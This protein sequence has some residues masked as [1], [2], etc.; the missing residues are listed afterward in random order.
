VKGKEW[1]HKF[2]S[3][4]TG[5]K[6]YDS[7]LREPPV[8]YKALYFL[9]YASQLKCYNTVIMELVVSSH[10]VKRLM[11]THTKIFCN[12]CKF[13]TQFLNYSFL[14]LLFTSQC[15]DCP[16]LCRSAMDNTK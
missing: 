15:G 7:V 14:L 5:I 6:T 2:F 3:L 4:V 9:Y 12:L 11:S 10:L 8:H 16:L 13:K 1:Q